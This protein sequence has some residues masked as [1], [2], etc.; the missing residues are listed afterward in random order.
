MDSDPDALIDVAAA[1]A[2]G[3]GIDWKHVEGGVSGAEQQD[4]LE[5]LRL[6]KMIAD[7]HQDQAESGSTGDQEEP[8]PAGTASTSP[9]LGQWGGLVLIEEIGQGSFGT[10]YRAHDPQLDR[11]VAVKLLRRASATD[12]QLASRLLHEGQTLARV[13][14]PNVVT[15]YGAGTHEGRVGLWME[16]VRG[17]TLEQMLGTHGSFS[18]GEAA[19]VGHELCGALAAVHVAGLVHRDIKAQNVMREQGGR[20]V[21]MDFGAGQKRVELRATGGRIVGTPFYMAPEVLSGHEATIRSD[22]YSLG[23]LLYHLVSND[24]PVKAGTVSDLVSA[25]AR[26]ER[27]PLQ[28]VRPHLPATFLRVVERATHPEPAKRFA[29]AG[30]LQVALDQAAGAGANKAAAPRLRTTLP[31]AHTGEQSRR[32]SAPG[33][34]SVAVLPFTDMSAAKDQEWFCDGMTEELISALA[35]IPGLRVAA[36]TSAFQFKGQAR[37][38]RHIGDA[39]TVATVLDGSVRKD[40]NRI[41]ITVELIGSSDGYHLWTERFDRNVDD[42][43]AVQT[44]IAASVARALKGTLAGV[45]SPVANIAPLRDVEAYESYLEGRYHWNKRTEDE[46]QK[47]VDC[48]ERAIERDPSYAQAYA[49]MA[50][51]YITLGTYGALPPKDVMTRAKRALKK[52]LEIDGELAEAYTCR[53]CVRSVYDWSWEDA[54]HDF[55]RAIA[56]NPSYPTAHHWYAINHLVPRGRFDQATEELRSALKC[57][58]LALAIKTSVGMKSYFARQYDD[59]VRELT[60]TISIDGGFGMA[61]FFLG[62]TYTEQGKYAEALDELQAATR[63]S[64][65]S[66]EILAAL[67]YLHGR[68]GDG[69]RARTVLDELKQ[70]ADTRY[71]SPAKIAQVHVG[72]GERAEA[73]AQLEEA[74]AERAGDLAW[75]GVR[76][77]FASLRAEPKFI[78]L[79]NQIGVEASART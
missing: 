20:L 35:Q 69:D 41:R 58:P 47:S 45:R 9:D 34:A 14:H 19:L 36:R 48:F 23:V 56:L 33:G 13:R 66:P 79:V 55:Q 24:F 32:G 30:A 17:L 63:L 11:P 46:L 37:D 15:V 50:D 77:V 31:K 65:R 6:I 78:A 75:L 8:R 26:G 42:V 60:R 51:A 72:L 39:L 52:A 57:D 40:G 71:V 64:G 28:D 12:E 38:V 4:R 18:G 2:D 25:H 61:R 67:G 44:E 3:S 68:W 21:L 53:G 7:M 16:F 76:P 10:V 43:F 5:Q 22:V 1:I 70:V 62:A 49:G 27:T 59:A 54:E 73:L 29:S 74:H